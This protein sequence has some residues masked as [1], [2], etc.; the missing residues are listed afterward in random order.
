MAQ[1][2]V[3]CGVQA[4][5]Q[6]WLEVVH[7]MRQGEDQRSNAGDQNSF[8]NPDLNDEFA[9]SNRTVQSKFESCTYRYMSIRSEIADE[10]DGDQIA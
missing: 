2:V 9:I 4:I 1:T 5:F 6:R 3:Q 8:A 10:Y 7:E